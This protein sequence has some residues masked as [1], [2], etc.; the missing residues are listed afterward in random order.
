VADEKNKEEKADEPKKKAMSPLVLIAVGAVLGGAGVV[1]GVPPKV[2]E[3]PVEHHA[4]EIVDWE[5][6]FEIAATFSPR[7]RA[8]QTVAKVSF[9]F[10]YRCSE[11]VVG[12]VHAQI[13]ASK[14]HAKSA[15]L[16]V[17]HETP[18]KSLRSKPGLEMLES[19]LI[20]VLNQEFFDSAKG[21]HA[22]QVTKI[23]WEEIQVQ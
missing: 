11:D 20:E 12:D 17:L 9:S 18:A 2:V 13:E 14:A 8:G 23:L 4:P 3:V 5:G 10:V 22:A 19:Q 6:P 1:V 21:E 15:V 16:L 7:T